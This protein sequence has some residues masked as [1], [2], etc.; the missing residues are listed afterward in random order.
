MTSRITAGHAL[1]AFLLATCLFSVVHVNKAQLIGGDLSGF[2]GGF[3]GDGFASKAAPPLPPGS[4]FPPK[5]SAPPLSPGS[6]FPPKP[7][8]PP[9]A[10]GGDVP[11]KGPAPPFSPGGGFFSKP[12]APPMPARSPPSPSPVGR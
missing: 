6:S 7:P 5:P 11:P 1:G 2:G 9:R 8:A 12:P 4:S 10:P 3:G